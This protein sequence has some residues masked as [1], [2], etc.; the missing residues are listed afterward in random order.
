MA[1]PFIVLATLL[2]GVWAITDKE[3]VARAHPFAV[4]W[5]YHLPFVVTLPLFWWLGARAE[6]VAGASRAA[7]P[8]AIAAGS[9]G[10]LATVFVVFALREM[11]ASAVTTITSF[12]PAVTLVIAVMLRQEVFTATK[13]LGVALVVAGVIVISRAES[14]PAPPAAP[15]ATPVL[16]GDGG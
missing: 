1:V 12:Y 4:Q 11:S 3:A 15:P 10:L 7:M 16:R 14:A 9:C 8:W 6:P 13:A 2:Y 5:M